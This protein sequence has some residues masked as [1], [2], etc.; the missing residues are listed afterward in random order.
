MKK[1]NKGTHSKAVIELSEKEIKIAI[2]DFLS[3]QEGFE[4]KSLQIISSLTPQRGV[5][6][7]EDDVDIAGL[8]FDILV[9]DKPEA[10]EPE[11]INEQPSVDKAIN[12]TVHDITIQE[13]ILRNLRKRLDDLYKQKEIVDAEK[14]Q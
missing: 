10:M 4:D 3:H 6:V 9:F 5:D 13:T 8:V 11:A 12:M 1:I 2:T 14:G 7:W